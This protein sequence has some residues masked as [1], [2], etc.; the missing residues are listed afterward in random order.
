MKCKKGSKAITRFGREERLRWLRTTSGTESERVIKSG[1]GVEYGR[2][3]KTVGERV[4]AKGKWK[5]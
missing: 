3:G 2:G 4:K 5:S 1:K